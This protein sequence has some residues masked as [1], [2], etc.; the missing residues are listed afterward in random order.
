MVLDIL[1]FVCN[2]SLG[3]ELLD[4]AKW[5]QRNDMFGRQ[6]SSLLIAVRDKSRDGSLVKPERDPL[7]E[8]LMAVG[9]GFR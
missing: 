3:L 4:F 8:G 1:S 5:P 7:M 9:R 6:N 2:R